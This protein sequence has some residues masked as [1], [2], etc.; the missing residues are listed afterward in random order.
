M[1]I[2]GNFPI[3]LHWSWQ[4]QWETLFIEEKM[5]AQFDVIVDSTGSKLAKLY[6]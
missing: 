3:C 5:V 4:P 1:A 6:R 2:K